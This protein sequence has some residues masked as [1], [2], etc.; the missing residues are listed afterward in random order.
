MSIK[1][2][3]FTLP[4]SVIQ[5]MKRYTIDSKTKNIEIGFNLCSDK[6]NHLLVLHDEKP[7]SGSECTL[8]IPKGCNSGK[9]VGL[10][11]THVSASSKP[12]IQDILNAY[13]FGINCIGSVDERNIKCYV[14]KDTIPTRENIESITLSIVRYENPLL[15]HTSSK[16]SPEEDIENYRKWKNVRNDLTKRYLNDIE[17]A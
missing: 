6:Q 13:Y 5:K 10:F 8:D 7:C 12:S 11:H 2:N 15:P 9:H 4:D 16:V 14:R 17:V 1:L 3:S